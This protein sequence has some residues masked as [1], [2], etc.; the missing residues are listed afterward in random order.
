MDGSAEELQ[1]CLQPN[2]ARTYGDTQDSQDMR[3]A[4]ARIEEIN[5]LTNQLNAIHGF[6]YSDSEKF[7]LTK[8]LLANEEAKLRVKE[9]DSRAKEIDSRARE[10]NLVTNKLK[11]INQL[12]LSGEEKLKL[13]YRFVDSNVDSNSSRICNFSSS[14]LS[15]V[16]PCLC[17][18]N[19]HKILPM[20][21]GF[22]S[23]YRFSLPSFLMLDIFGCGVF[24]VELKD[25]GGEKSKIN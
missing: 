5:A 2:D 25:M 8:I 10:A 24:D 4:H 19:T 23:D 17:W 12:E 20:F 14:P 21:G 9:I 3:L 18:S 16:W 6:Q 15:M 22:S 1:N 13:I 7:E 11:E